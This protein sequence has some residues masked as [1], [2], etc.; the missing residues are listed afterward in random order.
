MSK[1]KVHDWLC[2]LWPMVPW[3]K[4]FASLNSEQLCH[5]AC[6]LGHFRSRSPLVEAAASDRG[7]SAY[8]F[9]VLCRTP[10]RDRPRSKSLHCSSSERLYLFFS[11]VRSER[12]TSSESLA[13]VCSSSSP[14]VKKALQK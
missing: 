12:R 11:V 2:Q 10:V 5:N 3:D 1:G 13:H 14:R 7:S 4:S 6:F 8:T 9:L